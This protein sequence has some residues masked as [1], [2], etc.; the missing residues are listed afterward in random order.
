MGHTDPHAPLSALKLARTP[1]AVRL[2]ALVVLALLLL[3]VPALAVSPW[4]QTVHGTGRAIA[5]NPVQRPQFVISPIEGRVKKWHVVEGDRVKAGQLLVELVDN[6]PMIL[7]RL[8][9]QETLAL[10][11]LALADGRVADH[12]QRLEF[13]K[14]ERE[15]LLAEADARVDQAEQQILVVR[16]EFDQAEV[17]LEREEQSYKRL[18]GLFKSQKGEVVSGDAVEEAERRMRV[19]KRQVALVAARLKL[20]E[21]ARDGTKAQ[22]EA[23]DKR[24]NGLIQTEEAAVKGAQSEQASVR[25]Q[26]NTIRTQV[27]RQSNQQIHAAVD[28][29]IF[30][31]LAN[32]EAGGQLVRP[33]ERL[34]VLVPDIKAVTPALTGDTHPGIVAELTID[35][36]DLPLVRAGDRVLLQFEGWAAVQ[37]AAYPEAAAGTFE[38]RV[39]LVDPTSDGQG[40]FRVLVEPAPGAAWP[41]EQFL[42]QG[43][44]AQGWIVLKEVRLGYEVWRLLNGFPPVR[45]V[46]D[47]PPRQPLG[48]VAK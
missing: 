12:Q 28:G 9:E 33:G 46:K 44:R 18:S 7:E 8:R 5:F 41:D 11:R 14:D 17:N 36:N 21:K 15:V 6:D 34:A 22:R 24:T 42:R 1:R 3:A 32:A 26:Y 2:L 37:F 23:T 27:E 40:H 30:R 47:K 48:P 45:E 4:T 13:V 35:G 31:V 25:Q 43:V 16:G 19:A 29:V 20:T 38:G 10:Q 39:Y